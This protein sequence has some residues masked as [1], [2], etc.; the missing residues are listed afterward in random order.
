MSLYNMINGTNP[1][2]PVVVSILGVDLQKVARMRDAYFNGDHFVILTRTGGGNRELYSEG[3]S[4]L[5][6][7]QGFVVSED[8]PNDPSYAIFKYEVPEKFAYLLEK[9]QA[10]AQRKTEGERW[11]EAIDRIKN[12]TPDDPRVKRMIEV[13]KPIFDSLSDD[14]PKE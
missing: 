11:A 13:F 5:E 10:H 3:N 9:L 4:Y 14:P 12:A 2:A 1:L 7:I 6:S 8:T